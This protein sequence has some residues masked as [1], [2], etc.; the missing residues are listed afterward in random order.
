MTQQSFNMIFH[1]YIT[2]EIR[3]ILRVTFT[4]KA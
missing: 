2:V 4:C 3:H 1:V